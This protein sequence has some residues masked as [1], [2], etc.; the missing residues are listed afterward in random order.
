MATSQKSSHADIEAALIKVWRRTFSSVAVAHEGWLEHAFVRRGMGLV[1]TVY[2][3]PDER[4]RLFQYGFTP[5]VGRRFESINADMHRILESTTDYAECSRQNRLDIFKQLGKLIADDRGFG[6][7]IR[8][9]V[10]DNWLLQN[11]TVPLNWWMQGPGAV[12]PNSEELRSWQRFVSDN[13]EFRLGGAIRAVI[14]QVWSSGTENP[15][16]GPSLETWRESTGLPWFGFWVQE[17]LR[18]GTLDP[19]VAFALSRG[20]ANTR[21]DGAKLSR[22]YKIWMAHENVI[23]EADDWI[24]P[25]KFLAWELSLKVQRIKISRPRHFDAELTGTDGRRERYSVLPLLHSG[26]LHWMDPSGFELAISPAPS[27]GHDLSHRDDFEL[28]MRNGIWKVSR[29]FRAA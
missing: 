24:D 4:R 2:K 8:S 22:D 12:S 21:A 19:F 27:S 10:A 1:S 13:I 23:N 20:L 18:W 29:V 26:K 25:R 7:R 17:L 9:T 5:C 6:F 3:N 14:T 28:R 16:V 15:M 11:W